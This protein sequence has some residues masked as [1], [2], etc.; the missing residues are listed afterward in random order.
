MGLKSRDELKAIWVTDAT[1]TEELFDDVWDSF[2]NKSSD[3]YP[4]DIDYRS[5]SSTGYLQS[6]SERVFINHS[7]E[8][9]ITGPTSPTV[10]NVY[11]IIDAS[12]NCTTNNIIF[13][14]NGF[15]IR[16]YNTW[17]LDADWYVLKVV[18]NGSSY[19]II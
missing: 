18:F 2:H 12:G 10:N 16:G 14:G 17:T 5:V 6:T 9:T 15:Q 3:T 7:S 1:I 19:N 4:K 8:I 11:E 13:D